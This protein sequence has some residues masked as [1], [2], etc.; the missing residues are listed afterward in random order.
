MVLV[1]GMVTVRSGSALSFTFTVTLPPS[2]TEYVACPKL[3]VTDGTSS[4]VMETTVSSGEPSVTPVGRLEPN[5]SLTDSLSSLS[6]SE[7]ALKSKVFS[8]SPLLKT[9]LAGRLE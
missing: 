1:R 3:T 5:P 2:A 6:L 8:V 9:T 7:A 4:S